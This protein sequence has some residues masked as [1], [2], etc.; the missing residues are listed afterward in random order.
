MVSP[1]WP[2]TKLDDFRIFGDKLETRG[3]P[4][5]SIYLANAPIEQHNR[6]FCAIYGDE[7]IAERGNARALLIELNRR[8]GF[9]YTPEV[10]HMAFGATVRNFID[11]VDEGIR[12]MLRVTR[13]GIRRE[14]LAEYSLY[15][16]KMVPFLGLP[17]QR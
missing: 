15:R 9:L 8:H 2:A 6:L 13:K 17:R 12:R 3:K 16:A 11:L 10:A 7:H 1:P 4:P 5:A 14:S